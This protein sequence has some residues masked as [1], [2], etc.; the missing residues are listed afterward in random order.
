[1][2]SDHSM[3]A[4]M[5]KIRLLA[6][7]FLA[8]FLAFCAVMIFVVVYQRNN[9]Q[10]FLIIAA[11]AFFLAG[12]LRRPGVALGSSVRALPAFLGGAIPIV[13]MRLTGAGFTA[14]GY[15]PLFLALSFCTA[16]AGIE[17][18]R[19]LSRQRMGYAAVIAIFCAAVTAGVIGSLVPPLMTRWSSKAVDQPVLPFSLTA[20]DGKQVTS[21]DLRGKVLVLAFWASW[22]TP[23][24]EEL[25]ELE[26]IYAQ[27]A[28]DPNVAF[29]AVGG[30]WG[31]DTL[32]KEA[33]FIR[34]K[35]LSLP[36]LFDPGGAAK[37]LLGVNAFP[38]LIILDKAGHI[39]LVHTGYD[40]SEHLDQQISRELAALSR[41]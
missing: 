32:E 4:P 37:R 13:L 20:S 31:D 24:N 34:R 41:S 18:R 8:G 17:T 33:A 38:S 30:P 11:A 14:P 6:W 16:F 39:R 12:L 9:S 3:E 21:A 40:A 2:R 10:L 15:V 35:K 19:S 5:S 25:P 26:K 29:Y 1:M 23:C 36:T 28:S 7:D 27:Y 22:C